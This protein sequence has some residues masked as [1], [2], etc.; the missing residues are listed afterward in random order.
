MRESKYLS[1]ARLLLNTSCAIS[2]TGFFISAELIDRAGG[3][4]WHLLTEDIEFSTQQILD[5]ERISFTPGPC[6]MTS[7]R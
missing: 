4:K 5:G 1:Q 3:W 2:G 7:S 6:S